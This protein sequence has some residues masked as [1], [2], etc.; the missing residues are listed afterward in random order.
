MIENYLDE[1]LK[2]GDITSDA[3]IK[4]ENAIAFIIAKED[5]MI[6]GLEEAKNVFEI[7]GL[8]VSLFAKDGEKVKEG[9][10][11]L[12]VKGKAKNILM[13][14]RLALN[15]IMRMSGIAT[16]TNELVE[17]C[18]K[19]NP[20]I[21]I[22]GTRKTTP[23]FRLY[24]KK[25]IEIGGGFAHRFNLGDGILIK[26]NHIKIVGT[27]EECLKRAKQHKEKYNLLY[28]IEI[29]VENFEQ[30][31]KAVKNKAEI[32]M[33]DNFSPKDAEKTVKELKKINKNIIIEISGGINEKN[34]TKYV[35]FA[36][37]ISLGMLTHSYKSKNFSL[38]IEKVV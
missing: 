31:I 10:K 2:N 29:E 15:F 3:L 21:K 17:K 6:A 11:I 36:D 18:K 13:A 23:G 19:I 35:K 32:I 25:A 20:K 16:M 14:E 27:I 8:K 12:K 24:E 37:I 30:S 5:C 38:E 22:A 34:I 28:K 33:L 4:D 1:D 9:I 26:D 7:F